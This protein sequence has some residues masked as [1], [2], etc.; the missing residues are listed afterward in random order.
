MHLHC[1]R[2]YPCIWRS[3]T[4]PILKL[5]TVK[6]HNP[7]MGRLNNHFALH[8]CTNLLQFAQN[9]ASIHNL[10]ICPFSPM[11]KVCLG[12]LLIHALAS[13]MRSFVVPYL[14]QLHLCIFAKCCYKPS[15]S[16]QSS[17][18]FC[19]FPPAKELVA[20]QERIVHSVMDDDVDIVCFIILAKAKGYSYVTYFLFCYT[21]SMTLSSSHHRSN[22]ASLKGLF[23]QYFTAA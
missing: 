17:T 22:F 14:Q 16:R 20:H 1:I 23:L 5:G 15:S 3:N 12:T 10:W 4:I 21:T 11:N 13:F 7:L 8:I 18:S 2:F 19:L 9:C 6:T